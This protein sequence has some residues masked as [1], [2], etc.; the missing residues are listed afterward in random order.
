MNDNHGHGRVIGSCGDTME[1]VL[2][3]HRGR[4]K[5]ATFTTDGCESSIACCSLAVEL[6]HGKTP[7][8]IKDITGE[9][10]FSAIGVL[11]GEEQHCAFLAS[12]TLQKALEDY[13]Q[14]QLKK[15]DLT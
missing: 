12:E 7:D 13:L 4:V 9:M 1:I 10:I 11:P 3:F 15:A 2:K 5:K 6:A 14:K 8:E